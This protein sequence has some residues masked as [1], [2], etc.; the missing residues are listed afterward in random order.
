MPAHKLTDDMTW[1]QIVEKCML[2]SGTKDNGFRQWMLTKE[3]NGGYFFG[4]GRHWLYLYN[5]YE[6]ITFKDKDHVEAVCGEEGGGKSTL[7][8]QQACTVDPTFCKARI[9]N[10]RIE[11]IRWLKS[12]QGT[13]KG[14]AIIIDEGNLLIFNREHLKTGNINIIKLFTLCRQCNLY[15]IICIPLF[16][17]IDS[18]LKKHRLHGLTQILPK[19]TKFVHYSQEGIKFINEILTK[20]VPYNKIRVP[21]HLW[22]NGH[23]N[24]FL[25][26]INDI[27]MESYLGVKKKAWS[28]FLDD[29]ED[30]ISTTAGDERFIH[31]QEAKK[32]LNLHHQTY[33]EHIEK[34]I[35]AGKRVGKYYFVDKN[36]LLD[37]VHSQK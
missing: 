24:K 6:K 28:D 13:T 34:G 23:W 36:A 17:T 32:I 37:V 15:I 21:E 2:E 14:K 11:L 9:F 33:R 27:S 35:I 25:P 10:E 5:V 1:P 30:R 26:T 20:A 16:T 3:N 22:H 19:I 4:D 8:I 7:A 12:N 31:I 29:T 18:Y